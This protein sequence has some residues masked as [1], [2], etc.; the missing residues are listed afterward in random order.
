M[1][2]PC[3]VWE[4]LWKTYVPDEQKDDAIIENEQE[5]K[6]P[7]DPSLPITVFYK[8]YQRG[9]TLLTKLNAAPT[10]ITL[11]RNAVASLKKHAHLTRACRKWREKT[12]GNAPA[13][14]ITWNNL[15]AH[16]TREI[17]LLENDPSTK[18]QDEKVNAV[19][20]TLNKVE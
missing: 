5:I 16:F 9:K 7:Y 17:N 8:Q 2:K 12:T 15:K 3:E 19:E 13:L 20:E 11:C 6:A 10:D 18:K 1:L 14:T 4:H